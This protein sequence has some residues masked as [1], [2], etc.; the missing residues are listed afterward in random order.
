M[1][2]SQIKDKGRYLSVD[3]ILVEAL[4]AED[5]LTQMTVREGLY[6]GLAD[7][8]GDSGKEDRR[9]MEEHIQRRAMT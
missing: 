6:G 1:S 2:A 7:P 9:D 4:V 5:M 3:H 8:R